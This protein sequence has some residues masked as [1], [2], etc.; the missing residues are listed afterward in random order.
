MCDLKKFKQVHMNAGQKGASFDGV[1]FN[2]HM[3]IAPHV[4]SNPFV[5]S[6]KERVDCCMGEHGYMV[7]EESVY[8]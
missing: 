2:E 3:D 7:E 6:D 8:M 4:K 5:P 1:H